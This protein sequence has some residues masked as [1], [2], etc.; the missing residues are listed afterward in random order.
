MTATHVRTRTEVPAMYPVRYVL[1]WVLAASLVATPPLMGQEP[2]AK[3]GAPCEPCGWAVGGAIGQVRH[4]VLGVVSGILTD[5]GGLG[6]GIA[7]EADVEVEPT[8]LLGGGVGVRLAPDVALR[9]RVFRGD[10]HGRI[11]ASTVTGGGSTRQTYT[12]SKLGRI[13]VLLAAAD[14]YWTPGP[15]TGRVVPF[16]FGGVG[17][18]RWD[19]SGLDELGA[20]PPL[21]QS[22]IS[23]PPVDPWLPS[24]VAGGGIAVLLGEGISLRLEASD[25]VSGNPFEDE[26]F[27]LGSSFSGTAAPKNL[28][29][30]V[31]FTAGLSVGFGG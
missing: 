24:G 30:S 17:A 22:P 27:R 26:E 23:L 8:L 31:S 1:V 21:V 4:S 11:S 29:H 14:L 7:V 16:L 13:R 19:I 20:L 9:L 2:G 25:H 10:T 12:F 6:L 3:A 15:Q 18:S 28:V 5:G